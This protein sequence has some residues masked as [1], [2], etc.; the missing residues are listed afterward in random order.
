MQSKI[1]AGTVLEVFSIDVPFQWF[2][3]K[4]IFFVCVPNIVS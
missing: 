2:M 4:A 1:K 3:G